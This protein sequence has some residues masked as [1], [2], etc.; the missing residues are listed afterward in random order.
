[1]D[2]P[3][4]VSEARSEATGISVRGAVEGYSVVVGGVELRVSGEDGMRL[5]T[6]HE[7]FKAGPASEVIQVFARWGMVQDE[8][9]PRL[10][11]DSGAPWRLMETRDGWRFDFYSAITPQR[12][13]KI[14][15]VDRLFSRCEVVLCGDFLDP[16]RPVDPLEYPLDEL[17]VVYRL[18]LGLG[19]E[20]HSCS[21]VDDHG[22]GLVFTGQSGDGKT[23]LARLWRKHTGVA[24]VSDDRTILRPGQGGIRM[25]ATPWDGEGRFA[26]QRE[27]PLAAVF[28]LEQA[29]VS[30]V[31]RLGAS[32]AVPLLLA[33]TFT[34]FHDVE[35]TAW[36]MSFLETVARSVPCFRLR[37]RPDPG[38]IESVR[39]A[40]RDADIG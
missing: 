28:V 24:V 16:S 14:A 19:L 37:F 11:F 1:M 33:R 8:S 13:Y 15:L 18:G 7:A 32:E 27:A 10:H 35:M 2:I 5:R 9:D 39:K 17:L 3:P 36:T 23:T 21:V 26:L 30:E 38:A 40:L 4:P 22:S 25:H 34:T 31:V 12:P 20:L 29:P 6:P